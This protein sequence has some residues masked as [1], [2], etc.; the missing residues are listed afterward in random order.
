MRYIPRW[1][2]RNFIIIKK[3]LYRTSTL[4]QP[5]KEIKTI[6]WQKDIYG[7]YP[8][9]KSTFRSDRVWTPIKDVAEDKEAQEVLVRARLHAVRGKGNSCFLVLREGF[10]TLQ[11]CAFKG[12]ATPKEMIKYMQAVPP[13]SIV[14]ITGKVV[15]P[16]KPIESCSQQV[17]LQVLKFFV[18][19]RAASRLPLQILDASRKVT[20]NEFDNEEDEP[21]KEEGKE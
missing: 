16:E 5:E 1:T 10:A 19:N 13:E 9:I 18:V 12:E 20:T 2:F 15:K 7:D 3:S 6:D 21:A 8:F 4:M 11:A 14:D 17:E